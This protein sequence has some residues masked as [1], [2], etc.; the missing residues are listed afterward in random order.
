MTSRWYPL[1]TTDDAF[2]DT[3]PRRY[4]HVVDI[5]VEP[6]EVWSAL[7]A[8]D[9]IV[10]WSNLLSGLRWTSP[11]PFGVGSTREV[12]IGPA[13][14]RERYYRWQDGERKSFYVT[15][16]SVPGL[17]RF[18]EDY[19]VERTAAG[20]RFTWTFAIEPGPVLSPLL[21][22]ADPVLRL[23]TGRAARGLAGHLA[24]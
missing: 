21:C 6:A 18:A 19:R 23:V 3:A 9:T 17:R 7:T 5:P 8:D 10:S 1:A 4:R 14:V 13:T 12:T 24:T 2:F 11:R 22:L 16:S 15:E 20:S